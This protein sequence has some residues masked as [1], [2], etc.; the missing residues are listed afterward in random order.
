MTAQATPEFAASEKPSEAGFLK[1]ASCPQDHASPPRTRGDLQGGIA[2]AP[3]FD[4]SA[5]SL[6]LDKGSNV[7]DRQRN[8]RDSRKRV[9]SLRGPLFCPDV[10]SC[11][12][13]ACFRSAWLFFVE[14][15]EAFLALLTG[16]SDCATLRKAEQPETMIR[17]ERVSFLSD[18]MTCVMCSV[19]TRAWKIA[20]F[21]RYRDCVCIVCWPDWLRLNKRKISPGVATTGDAGVESSRTHASN[22]RRYVL[23]PFIA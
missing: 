10:I 23:R 3:L 7:A 18:R 17:P 21:N 15:R 22:P 14:L 12:E 2:H 20:Q 5:R 8:L 19:E 16:S 9:A 11:D 6:T 13:S 4:G 1:N